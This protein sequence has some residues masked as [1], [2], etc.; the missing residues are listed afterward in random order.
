MGIGGVAVHQ[1]VCDEGKL[2]YD[3]DRKALRSGLSEFE[4]SYYRFLSNG[5]GE[6]LS[7]VMLSKDTGLLRVSDTREIV[8]VLANGER[9]YS[10]SVE[11]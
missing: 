4:V 5:I 7:L 1:L 3:W 9:I 10:T 2:A 8:G 11:A 6:R